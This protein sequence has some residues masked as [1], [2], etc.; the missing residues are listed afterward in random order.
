M[1]FGFEADHAVEGVDGF[2]CDGACGAEEG[3]GEYGGEF[4]V[5]EVFCHGFDDC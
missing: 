5:N 1:F 3:V 2:E 4:E